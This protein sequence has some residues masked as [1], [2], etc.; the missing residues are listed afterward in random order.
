MPDSI[1]Q[2]AFADLLKSDT[3]LLDV[4]AP[5][6]YSRGS[7]PSASNI[8]L[9]NDSA[10]EQVG[11]IYKLQGANAALELGHKLIHA[12]VKDNLL[13][14]WQQHLEAYPSSVLYCYRGGQRSHIA[15][16]WL[17]EAGYDVPL[18]QGGFKAL[19]RF[20]ID[21]LDQVSLTDNFIIAGGKTGSGKTHL[22]NGLNTSVDLEGRANHRGSAFG[23][24]VSAQPA[25]IDFENNLAIDFIKLPSDSLNRIFIEDESHSIGSIHLP[26][27]FYAA[28]KRSPLAIIEAT[29]ASRTSV[30]FDDYIHSNYLDFVAVHGEEGLQLFSESLMTNLD[31]IRRRL[32]DDLYS[33]VQGIMS[34]AL[35]AQAASGDS[36]EHKDWIK[37][38]LVNYYDPMYDYQLAK[39]S[40]RIVFRG[41]S[42][43]FVSW[44]NSINP[45]A[46]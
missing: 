27:H 29:V 46:N 25:Q 8:A 38:L 12:E 19:R 16:Q 6:E 9:L 43:E 45:E 1:P 21:T 18:V 14:H 10:R 2:T 36:S 26:P 31:K 13:K 4:R 28:M 35:R 34:S 22:I 11:T 41:N 20:L 33:Q 23:R 7:F 17:A 40:D 39:K 32:G 42:A 5:I 44:A 24:R 3:P 37:I 15:Q 30:I